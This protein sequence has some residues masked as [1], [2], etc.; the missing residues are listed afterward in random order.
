[1]LALRFTLEQANR[2]TLRTSIAKDRASPSRD[3]SA[4]GARLDFSNTNDTE[5]VGIEYVRSKVY[6]CT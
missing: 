5:H 3:G 1:M 4:I 6:R 2:Q